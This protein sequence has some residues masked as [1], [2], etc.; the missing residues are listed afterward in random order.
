VD[1]I[2]EAERVEL[3]KLGQFTHMGFDGDATSA[4]LFWEVSPREVE[5][6]LYRNGERTSCTHDQALR[7]VKPLELPVIEPGPKLIKSCVVC[8]DLGC[9]HCPKV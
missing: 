3:W 7:I 1:A 2:R 4:L 5:A 9:E 6:L 8:N